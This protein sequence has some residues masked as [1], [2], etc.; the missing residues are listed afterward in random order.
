MEHIIEQVKSGK[1]NMFEEIV[2]TYQNRIYLYILKMIP[3]CHIAEEL[4]QEVFVTAFIKLDKYYYKDSFKA[5]LYKIAKNKTLNFIKK[6]KFEE[7]FFCSNKQSNLY[8]QDS[9][10]NTH[11]DEQIENTLS[12]LKIEDKNLLL[13]RSVEEM[14]YEELA[15]IYNANQATIRKRYERIK[16]RFRKHYELIEEDINNARVEY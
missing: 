15:I 5:W 12:K 3:N 14:S 2:I 8:Y 10:S 16:R 7:L 11:F 13:L 4:T 9:I 6:R 1:T